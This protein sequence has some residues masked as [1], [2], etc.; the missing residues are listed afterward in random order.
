MSD[1]P[2]RT[3]DDAI[4][5]KCHEQYAPLC[6][7]CYDKE[8]QEAL[9]LEREVSDGLEEIAELVIGF[10]VDFRENK[11]WEQHPEVGVLYAKIKVILARHAELRGKR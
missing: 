10:C 9:R 5:N 3:V 1:T 8:T 4:C 6:S 7:I 2:E 11:D